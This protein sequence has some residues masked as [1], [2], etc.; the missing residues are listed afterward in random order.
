M[1]PCLLMVACLLGVLGVA[2]APASVLGGPP[3]PA[4]P[5][6]SFLAPG[7]GRPPPPSAGHPLPP[8][9]GHPLPP[10]SGHPLPPGSGSAPSDLAASDRVRP[11]ILVVVPGGPGPLRPAL[12]ALCSRRGRVLFEEDA[13][14]TPGL[15]QQEAD[16]LQLAAR[17]RAA[18]TRARS[19]YYDAK[20]TEAAGTIKEVLADSS[21][22]LA[23]AGLFPELRDLFFWLAVSLSKAG[24][25]EEAQAAFERA[26]DL[27]LTPPEPGLFPPEVVSVLQSGFLAAARRERGILAVESLP[28]EATIAVNGREIG[29]SPVSLELPAG[30]HYVGATRFGFQPTMRKVRVNAG[31]RLVLEIALEPA[32]LP[33]LTE[34]LALLRKQGPLDL[35]NHEVVAALAR[36]ARADEVLTVVRHRANDR[37]RLAFARLSSD[38][39]LLGRCETLLPDAPQEATAAILALAPLL[40][41]EAS[42]PS[43]PSPPPP[44]WKR[45]WF[46]GIAASLVAGTVAGIAWAATRPDTWSL[47]VK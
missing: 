14:R 39:R 13:P 21:E 47:V 46:W 17:V 44:L 22:L 18:L 9:S 42:P 7:S 11:S 28:R 45:W 15:S 23:F 32:S 27:G 43:R 12:A 1:R 30:E 5:P 34:Q 2:L 38:G 40:W 8:G 25:A 10:A 37:V 19:L 20:P 35:E 4:E 24:H 31:T 16:V 36:I 3:A 26:F 41:P 6:R 33:V 29:R